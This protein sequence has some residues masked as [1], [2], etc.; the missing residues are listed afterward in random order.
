MKVLSQ[1]VNLH[2]IG[3][4]KPSNIKLFQSIYCAVNESMGRLMK[5]EAPKLPMILK[6]YPADFYNYTRNRFLKNFYMP[7]I[8]LLKS[9][10]DNQGALEYVTANGYDF[11]QHEVET[12]DGYIL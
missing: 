2:E 12:E 10:V 8:D 6:E 1:V 11:E 4:K 9:N 7:T 3:G 5:I